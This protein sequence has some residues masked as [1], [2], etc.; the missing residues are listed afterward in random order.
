MTFRARKIKEA[1]K[2]KPRREKKLKFTFQE[3][4]EFETIDDEIDTL[5][6]KIEQFNQELIEHATDYVKLQDIMAQKEIIEEELAHKYERW[7][8]LNQLAE[9]I[10]N[11]SK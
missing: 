7:E 5:E 6:E 3:Q 2:S 11:K 9:E 8:Y 10:E 4:K 1:S